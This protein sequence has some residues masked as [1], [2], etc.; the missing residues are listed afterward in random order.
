MSKPYEE[1][2]EK[3]DRLADALVEDILATSDE[4]ILKEAEEDYDDDVNAVIDNMR[5]L[6]AKTLLQR[7]K[8]KLALARQIY[9]Q[10][11]LQPRATLRTMSLQEKRK[12]LAKIAANDIYLRD[13]LTL[14]ARQGE[15][16]SE[17]D[18]DSMI[19]ALR[20][21]HLIDEEGNPK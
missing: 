19:E 2:Q 16:L 13:K 7:N 15:E 4:D 9:E 18:L 14:A 5:Q 8:R 10:K 12:L 11:A 20:D 6:I 1:T 21:L 3:L 17:T